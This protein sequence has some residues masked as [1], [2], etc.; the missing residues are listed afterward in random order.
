MQSMMDCHGF[1][2]FDYCIETELNSAHDLKVLD[3][4]LITANRTALKKYYDR[5][6]IIDA[7]KKSFSIK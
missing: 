4:E 6:V 2:L 5:S 3:I 1:D 7:L